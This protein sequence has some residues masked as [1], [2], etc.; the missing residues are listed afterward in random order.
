MELLWLLLGSLI[1]RLLLRCL[2]LGLLLLR[3]SVLR[4][5]RL[6]LS[7]WCAILLAWLLLVVGLRTLECW[8]LWSGGSFGVKFGMQVVGFLQLLWQWW[9]RGQMIPHRLE[10]TGIGLILDAVQFTIRAGVGISSGNDL[11]SQFRSNL[12]VVALFLVLDSVTGGVV[13]PI[14]SIAVVHVFISQN[15]DRGGA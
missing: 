8:V 10:T 15:R 12:A 5:R 3:G 11:F 13:E 7:L 2:I 14:A 1:L 9:W 6:V 4:A